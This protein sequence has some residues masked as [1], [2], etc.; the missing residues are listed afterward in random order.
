MQAERTITRYRRWYRKLLRCYSRPHRERFA[1]S[2]E[3]T[4]NDLCRERRASG[5][6]LFAIVLWMSVETC[7]G[8]I[9]ENAATLMRSTMAQDSTLFLR[10]IKYCA[11]TLSVLMVAGIAAL[12]FLARGTG[13]DIT[14]IVAPALL[15]TLVSGAVAIVMAVLQ[16]RSQHA[17]NQRSGS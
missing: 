15:I 4:F 6:G 9:R 2:M 13:E 10:I 1:E 14:G 17:I 7:V 8:I 12:M 16:R 3:Q 5:K 11:I